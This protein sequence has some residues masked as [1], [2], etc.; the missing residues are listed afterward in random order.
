MGVGVST[1]EMM[2]GNVGS[3][4]RMDYTVIGH[5]VN[6]AAR[7]CSAAGDRQILVSQSCFDSIVRMSDRVKHAMLF[8]PIDRIRAG[9]SGSPS[10]CSN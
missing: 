1:G 7:L 9:A 5:H 3:E 10:R 4:E 2:M 8:T 6:L